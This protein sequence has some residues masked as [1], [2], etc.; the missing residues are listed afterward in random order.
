MRKRYHITSLQPYQRSA[1]KA[2]MNLLEFYFTF[3]FFSY[4]WLNKCALITGAFSGQSREMCDHMHDKQKMYSLIWAK[5]IE[6][7]NG[8]STLACI[9]VRKGAPHQKHLGLY[10]YYLCRI[11]LFHQYTCICMYSLNTCI[12]FCAF[13]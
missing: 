6:R 13:C 2:V 5:Y 4:T 10:M 12:N 9:D 8:S 11:L 1:I 7:R 3:F